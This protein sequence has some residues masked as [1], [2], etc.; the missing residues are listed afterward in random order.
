ML[1]S[2][3]HQEHP[4]PPPILVIKNPFPFYAFFNPL[5][6]A[7]SIHI[8]HSQQLTRSSHSSTSFTHV[9]WHH[10]FYDPFTTTKTLFHLVREL[11]LKSSDATIISGHTLPFMFTSSTVVPLGPFSSCPLS[12]WSF[13][14]TLPTPRINPFGLRVATDAFHDFRFNHFQIQNVSFIYFLYLLF[15]FHPRYWFFSPLPL[16]LLFG[17]PTFTCPPFIPF[18]IHDPSI[19]L[20]PRTPRRVLTTPI[21]LFLRVACLALTPPSIHP[22]TFTPSTD[23][24]SGGRDVVEGEAPLTPFSPHSPFPPPAHTALPFIYTHDD[25]P[26]LSPPS[27]P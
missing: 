24:F 20:R 25:I 5:F 19:Q 18:L 22:Y 3:H 1:S 9:A 14:A 16:A 26:A 2:S 7:Y 6:F 8:I 12:P 23:R 13:P 17:G 4:H 11:K 27:A 15:T 10:V 21:Y